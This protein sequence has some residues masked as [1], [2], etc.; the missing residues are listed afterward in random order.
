MQILSLSMQLEANT[1]SIKKLLESSEAKN[2]ETKAKLKHCD[3]EL[4]CI[5]KDLANFNQVNKDFLGLVKTKIT[6]FDEAIQ[7]SRTDLE[8]KFKEFRVEKKNTDWALK[9]D[10]EA[11]L[12]KFEASVEA[13]N[14][15]VI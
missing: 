10:M 1:K 6:S 13:T 14:A 4:I 8:A 15:K 11:R 7:D 9:M 12:D 5:K 3:T 2:E